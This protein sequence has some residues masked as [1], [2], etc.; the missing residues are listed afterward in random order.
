MRILIRPNRHMKRYL[1]QI[2]IT[3]LIEPARLYHRNRE[4][5]VLRKPVRQRQPRCSAADNDIVEALVAG[6]TER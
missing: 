4:S 1:A 3:N 5:W 6:H 2:P